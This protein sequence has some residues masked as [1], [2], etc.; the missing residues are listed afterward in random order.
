[1]S[2]PPQDIRGPLDPPWRSSSLLDT[3][4]EEANPVAESETEELETSV[5]PQQDSES[6]TDGGNNTQSDDATPGKEV[7]PSREWDSRTPGST[8]VASYHAPY[9]ESYPRP[10]NH[11][12]ST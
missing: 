11:V 8:P 1:M 3:N 12:G 7:R 9:P 4:M 2:F 10:F 6:A 5:E